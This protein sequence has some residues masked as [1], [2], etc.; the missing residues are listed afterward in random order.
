MTF[1][2]ELEFSDEFVN[3][4]EGRTWTLKMLTL[5]SRDKVSS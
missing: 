2:C 4:D 5:F 3:F 1:E